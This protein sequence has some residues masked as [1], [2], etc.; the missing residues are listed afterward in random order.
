M[1]VFRN[2]QISFLAIALLI[3]STTYGQ[4]AIIKV[5]DQKTNE[6]VPYAHVCFESVSSG[7][8]RHSMTNDDGEVVNDCPRQAIIAVTYVGYET[9]FDTINSGES[10]TIG[11]KPAVLNMNE[12][13]VTAQ[14]T[15]QRVDKSIYKIKVIG[16]KQIEQKAATNLRDLFN[17]EL[18]IRV[19]QDA[20]LGASMSIRGLSGEHV[21]FLVDGVPMI[22]RMNGNI[23]L[24]QINLNNVDHVEIIEGPM[25]VV[26]G[27]NALAGVVNIITKQ[28]RNTKFEAFAET[29]TESVG[30]FNINGAVS[31]K[32][33]KNI[34]SLAGARNFFGGYSPETD[35]DSRDLQWKPKRQYSFDGSYL[36]DNKKYK[37]RFTSQYFNEKLWNKG[38]VIADLYAYD[39]YFYTTRF[40]N[41]LDVSSKIGAHRYFSVI[42]AYSIYDRERETF[43]K[44]LHTLEQYPKGGDTTRFNSVTFRPVIS[45]SKDDSKLNYQFG[46]DFNIENGKGEKITGGEQSIG[47]YAGFLSLKYDPIPSLT[48]QPGLRLIYNTNYQ[49]PLVYSLNLK[50]NA[51]EYMN[52][53]ASFARG[54]RAPSLKELYLYFVDVNH[55]IRGNDQLDAEDSYN[56]NLSY[57]FN[58]E[59]NK[60]LYGFEF[61]L[62]YN[63]I[64]NLITLAKVN[65]TEYTYINVDYFVSQGFQ[66][67]LKYSHYP[68]ITWKI[69]MILT[70]RQNDLEDD[71]YEVNEFYYTTDVT[72]SLTYSI[73]KIDLDFSVFYKYTGK[74]PQYQ[75][76]LNENL[77]EGYVPAYNSMD[78]SVI[79]NL[80]NRRL[81]LSIGVKN[82]FNNTV[83]PAVGGS[84]GEIHSGG[85]NPIAWGRTMFL[86]AAYTFKKF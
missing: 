41:T 54:F 50:W 16:V 55:D 52:I 11:L 14:Y 35:I 79:K 26:Y 58:R 7:E 70:G 42:A 71:D 74:T 15:P 76:D 85:D 29:Y 80:M 23:D 72:S 9:L 61:D 18:G 3:I 32:K 68:N 5:L 6:P 22:G 82:L 37:I 84:S 75:V 4:Q 77:V 51:Q 59:S 47:D 21:K 36:Y 8:Q 86:R 48:I 65:Q 73:V 53:R 56:V 69:G 60:V 57:D 27:S 31:Y 67:E 64:N 40:T 78:I 49:A 66:T 10:V 13:V 2:I 46:L 25:S 1:F 24:G 33:K 81:Q 34:F 30:V 38:N 45:K 19:S 12:V 43:F 83:L 44:N 28:N 17:D 63:K 39:T 20:A 62:F